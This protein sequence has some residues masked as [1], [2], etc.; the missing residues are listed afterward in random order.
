MKKLLIVEDNVVNLDLVEQ[1]LEDDYELVVATDGG[2]AVEKA[3]A[4][5]PDLI[6]MD[7]SIPVLDGW[8]AI[9][10]IRETESVAA[11]PILAVSAHAASGDIQRALEAGANGYVTKPVDEDELLERIEHALGGGT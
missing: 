2:A 11:T 9:R 8:A 6:L 10:K 3:I 7:L 5:K 1:I 4:E